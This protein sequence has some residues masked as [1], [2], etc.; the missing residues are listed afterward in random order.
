MDSCRSGTL[1]AGPPTLI[2]ACPECR[3]LSWPP[4]NG[5][6]CLEQW[7]LISNPRVRLSTR[8][9]GNNASLRCG[10]FFR[11]LYLPRE[12]NFFGD[13][14]A[15]AMD[16]CGWPRRWKTSRRYRFVEWNKKAASSIC[17]VVRYQHS[18]IHMVIQ[19]ASAIR[20]NVPTS[21]FKAHIANRSAPLSPNQTPTIDPLRHSKPRR[22]T[23][24]AARPFCAAPAIVD[25]P[26][27]QGESRPAVGEKPFSR[28]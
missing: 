25:D 12:R 27:S 17:T 19:S 21:G 8:P 11:D 20:S 18:L 13:I 26:L 28:L 22:S 24:T 15:N 9:S 3:P 14:S 6:F 23:A 4:F 5:E 1:L 16:A 7:G 2:R 10:T